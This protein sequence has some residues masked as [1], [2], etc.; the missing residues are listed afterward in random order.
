[1]SNVKV[2]VLMAGLTALFGAL[3]ASFG[4]MTGLVIAL[5]LGGGMNLFMYW[6]SASM[7][8]RSYGAQVVER[9]RAPE[10]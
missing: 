9:A 4:G 2:F 5:V 8:L 10:L 6:N 7:V 3:G 1:M